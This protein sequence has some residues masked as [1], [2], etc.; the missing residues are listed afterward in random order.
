MFQVGEVLGQGSFATVKRVIRRADGCVFAA[1]ILG[2]HDTKG[3]ERD[4]RSEIT[5]LKRIQHPGIIGLVGL[6]ESVDDWYIVTEIAEGGEL[7]HRIREQ[8]HFS[9]RSAALI[10]KQLLNAV[11]YIH[12]E[13]I[14]HR[15]LKPENILLMKNEDDPRVAI[16]DFGLATEVRTDNSLTHPCGSA[17]YISPESLKDCG[18]GR[19]ADV[20]SLGVIAYI[21]LCGYQPFWSERQYDLFVMVMNGDYEFDDEGWASIS[22]KAKAFV[23]RMLTV[24]P[25]RR[26]TAKEMLQDPWLMDAFSNKYQKTG[27]S[28]T[29]SLKAAFMKFFD[30]AQPQPADKIQIESSV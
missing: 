4:I 21:L 23:A 15:D 17:A 8:G 20:W 30:P 5:I 11:A 18:Y 1:R 24:N 25:E 22:N 19:P 9:E 27:V 29:R 2:K 7:F 26:P 14:V 28:R 10:M 6:Y 12:G 3:T 16:T 13:G